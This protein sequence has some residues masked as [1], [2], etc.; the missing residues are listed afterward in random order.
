MKHI[1]NE[2]VPVTVQIYTWGNA[3]YVIYFILF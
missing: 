3:K 1:L 2:C